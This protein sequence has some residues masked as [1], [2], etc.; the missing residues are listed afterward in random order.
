MSESF[1]QPGQPESIDKKGKN[2]KENMFG[3]SYDPKRKRYIV[4]LA[5]EDGQPL[6]QQEFSFR[7]KKNQEEAL[8]DALKFR[9]TKVGDFLLPCHVT[10]EGVKLKNNQTGV[11]GVH[12]REKILENSEETTRYVATW[13]NDDHKLK[14]IEFA[15][16]KWGA[17]KA[18]FMAWATRLSEERIFKTFKKE[19]SNRD[20][21]LDPDRCFDM[22]YDAVG[23]N[24]AE[25]IWKKEEKRSV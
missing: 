13:Y 7:G 10:R 9:D 17:K 16:N 23:G 21:I 5:H 4:R 25:E 20:A 12:R 8:E 24:R 1:N 3:I 19:K 2:K 6:I 15:E 14:K 18:F 11:A 22:V